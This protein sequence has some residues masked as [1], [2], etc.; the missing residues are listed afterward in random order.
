MGEARPAA[1]EPAAARAVPVR[2]L[3]VTKRFGHVVAVDDVTLEI[4]PGQLV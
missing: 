4:P 3:G 1:P 2:L